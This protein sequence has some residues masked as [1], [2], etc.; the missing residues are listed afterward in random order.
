MPTSKVKRVF[1]GVCVASRLAMRRAEVRIIYLKSGR[2]ASYTI[3]ESLGIAASV[4]IV[5]LWY[6]LRSNAAGLRME[7]SSDMALSKIGWNAA[8]NA[9]N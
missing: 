7:P 4:M 2:K 6:I 9:S 1:G 3:S 8:A 5:I